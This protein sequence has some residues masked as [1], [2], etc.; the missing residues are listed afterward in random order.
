MHWTL[1]SANAII[2]LSS[3]KL[4]NRLDDYLQRRSTDR[5]AT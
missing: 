3:A 1:R 2:A 4:S 5:Q